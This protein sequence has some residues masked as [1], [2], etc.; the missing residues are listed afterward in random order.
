MPG[1][2]LRILEWCN[3]YDI[4]IKYVGRKIGERHTY[5]QIEIQNGVLAN[6]IISC[7][8]WWSLY[9]KKE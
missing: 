7:M 6:A 4:S 5:L 8:P 3:D 9:D 2:I 1:E